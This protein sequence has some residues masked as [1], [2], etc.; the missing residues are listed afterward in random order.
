M[1]IFPTIVY[2]VF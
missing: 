1:I 2:T